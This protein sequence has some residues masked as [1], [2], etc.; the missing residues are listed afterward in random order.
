MSVIYYSHLRE[1][2]DGFIH[3]HRK[4][5]MIDTH[6]RIMMMGK[7]TTYKDIVQHDLNG[8]TELIW[9]A[10][11]SRY[12]SMPYLIDA[13]YEKFNILDCT[14]PFQDKYLLE[15]VDVSA[16]KG[17]VLLT[18][19][20]HAIDYTDGNAIS[21]SITEFFY[22]LRGSYGLSRLKRI[23]DE[24]LVSK[25]IDG[26]FAVTQWNEEKKYGYITL[27]FKGESIDIRTRSKKRC[28][29]RFANDLDKFVK[30][31]IEKESLSQ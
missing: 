4:A 17:R 23:V 2:V 27:A 5:K 22:R 15:V 6:V 10:S 3:A 24:A 9:V 20:L 21:N 12:Y 11:S 25:F 29:T 8:D 28:T 1:S 18:I 31:C 13:V 30:M 26:A 14:I 7:R 16:H 19:D